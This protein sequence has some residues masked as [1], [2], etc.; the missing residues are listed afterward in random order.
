[1]SMVGESQPACHRATTYGESQANISRS[2]LKGGP[3]SDE[4]RHY[5][6][7]VVETAE[8]DY[9]SWYPDVPR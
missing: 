9:A 8:I 4:H 2:P 3:T 6:V 7:E 5:W 1:M